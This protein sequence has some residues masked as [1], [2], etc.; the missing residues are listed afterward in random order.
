MQSVNSYDKFLA[1][2]NNSEWGQRNI[3]LSK[4]ISD[5]VENTTYREL[6]KRI[7]IDAAALHR[8]ESG[9]S[10]DPLW[11]TGIKIVRAHF[12]FTEKT[13]RGTRIKKAG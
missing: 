6:G 1:M 7:G 8:I 2:K 12:R 13:R 5:M 4:M 9:V 11:S 3:D 10:S